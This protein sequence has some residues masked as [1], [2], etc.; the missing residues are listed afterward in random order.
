MIFL[1]NT[2]SSSFSLYSPYFQGSHPFA[3]FALPAK[4]GLWGLLGPLSRN[5]IEWLH[6]HWPEQSLP[7]TTPYC[8][9][10]RYSSALSLCSPRKRRSKPRK[11]LCRDDSERSA[12]F[13][14]AR[15]HNLQ[16]CLCPYLSH[17]AAASCRGKSTPTSHRNFSRVHARLNL[18]K[19]SDS[20]DSL[21]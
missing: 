1:A 9:R 4:P 12:R 17:R 13:E 2:F 16:W 18:W 10:P 15:S 20:S 21:W 3:L 11:P 5:W 8:Q 14:F 7:W 19:L 6:V